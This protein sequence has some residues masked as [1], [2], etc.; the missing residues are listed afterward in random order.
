M[1]AEHNGIKEIMPAMNHIPEGGKK[2]VALIRMVL[3]DD[4]AILR[5]GLKKLLQREDDFVVVGEASDGQEA[6]EKV[7]ALD[8]DILLLDLRMPRMDGLSVL[9]ALQQTNTHTRVMVFTAS[10]D[11]NE[12]VRA[13][14]LGC[15]GIVLKQTAPDLIV[16]SIRKVHDGEICLDSHTTAAVM[17]QFSAG[18][19]SSSDAVGKAGQKRSPLSIREREIVALVVQGCRNKEIAEKTFISEQTV[20]NHLYN[21]FHKLGVSDR[22][23]LTLYAIHKGLCLPVQRPRTIATGRRFEEPGLASRTV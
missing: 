21:I 5:D 20:K 10:E 11:Q 18:R 6:I 4:H 22:L 14:K 12:F 9:R 3:A 15:G 1:S 23:E 7:Q 17:R 13:M 19:E 16:K 8:P 2:N